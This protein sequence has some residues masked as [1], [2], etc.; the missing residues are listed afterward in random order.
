MVTCETAVKPRA[1]VAPIME[2]RPGTRRCVRRRQEQ[3]E[4]GGR[5]TKEID[6]HQN[7]HLSGD[8]GTPRHLP[9]TPASARAG[10]DT[11]RAAGGHPQQPHRVLHRRERPRRARVRPGERL[12]RQPRRGAEDH[13]GGEFRPDH[14]HHHGRRG[15]HGG[16]GAVRDRVPQGARA[17]Q[18]S[19]SRGDAAP[20]LPA[21]HRQ[22]P[23]RGRADRRPHRGDGRQQPRGDARV[24]AAGG[25][26]AGLVGGAQRRGGRPAHERRRRRDRLYGGRLHGFQ[27]HPQLPPRAA[28]GAGPGDGRPHRLGL[29][30]GRR[31][32]PGGGRQ[33]VP[34]AHEA[35]WPARPHPRTLL[36]P[37]GQV[38]LRGHPRLHAPLRAAPAPLPGH[39]RGGGRREH[40]RLAPAGR[41]GLPGIPLAPRR[42]VAHRRAR[43]HD[44]D[45]GDGGLSRH[46]GPGGSGVEHLRRCAFPPS[47]EAA[48]AGFHQGTG[49]HLDVA[50]RLQRGLWPSHGRPAHRRDPGRQSGRL[51]RRERDAAPAGPAQVVLAADVRLRPGLGAGAVRGERA[52]VPRYPA[53]AHR[54]GAA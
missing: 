33:P 2:I 48:A 18:H 3:A 30:G 13:R 43:H 19:L 52:H 10:E 36:R 15:A 16:G 32:Q 46:R 5:A 4:D 21:R 6:D 12:R 42:R 39:V 40:H 38:R 29:P 45:R 17:V 25:P 53:L 54:P 1:R 20:D 8:R 51:D 24:A 41:H 35:G 31:R 23:Q 14:P 49:P 34:A 44:A 47:A 27:H 9:G 22:A 7:P 26:R 28:R 37:H 50:R 11:R